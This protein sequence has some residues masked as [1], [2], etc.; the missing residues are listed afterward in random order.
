[1]PSSIGPVGILLVEQK[2]RSFV[3][4]TSDE[5]SRASDTSH[6]KARADGLHGQ[7]IE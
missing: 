1:M 5:G 7:P 4:N 2:R 3:A 6:D